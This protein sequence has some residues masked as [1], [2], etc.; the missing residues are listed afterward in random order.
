MAAAE[1]GGT[2]LELLLGLALKWGDETGLPLTQTLATV[3]SAPV[4][5]LG[6]ALGSLAASAGRIV[7]GGV[8]D[9]CLFDPDAHWRVEPAALKSR[10]RHTPFAGIELPGRVAATLVAGHVAFEVDTAPRA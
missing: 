7:E 5:V 2:G 8:A 6:N 3:T 1:P 4:A 9:L 10:G